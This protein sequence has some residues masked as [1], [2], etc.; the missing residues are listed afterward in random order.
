MIDVSQRVFISLDGSTSDGVI[1]TTWETVNCDG[2]SQ[3]A[4]PVKAQPAAAPAAPQPV[5]VTPQS[6][7]PTSTKAASSTASTTSKGPSATN[8]KL[9]KNDCASGENF[10]S[11]L[12]GDTC[13]TIS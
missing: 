2:S 7:P 1:D 6:P 12:P 11:L 4:A 8:L 3:Q 10:Y 9:S 13:W 5:A